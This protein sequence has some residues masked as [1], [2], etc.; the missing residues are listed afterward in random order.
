[1]DELR[2]RHKNLLDAQNCL[3]VVIDVQER[4]RPHIDQYEELVAN[5]CTLVRAAET[6]LLP[7]VV[8]EQYTRGLGPTVSEIKNLETS[9]RPW[10]Y[11]EKNCFSAASVD[12][13]TD[14]LTGL[15]RRQ[16]LVCGIEA[17]V[18][19]NQTVHELLHL[20]YQTHVLV[21]AVASRTAANKE[22]ALK[23]MFAAGA[24]PAT[25]EMVLFEMLVTAGTADFKQVQSLV[26]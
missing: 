10:R 1:M 3:L 8:T 14:H 6:L 23:K 16:I 4:F 25:V 22:V 19:V 9:E 5:I 21:D 17:H 15:S 24:L 7:L 13:F 12:G 20:G 11:F 2:T 26:K 18:C